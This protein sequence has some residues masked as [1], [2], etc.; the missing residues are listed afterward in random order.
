MT[1]DR[2]TD[3]VRSRRRLYSADR[4]REEQFTDPDVMP[5]GLNCAPATVLLRVRSAS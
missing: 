2:G 1:T 3:P 5:A 4:R